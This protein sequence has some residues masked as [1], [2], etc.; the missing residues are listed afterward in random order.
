LQN[1]VTTTER[2]GVPHLVVRG[3]PGLRPPE[4]VPLTRSVV[5]LEPCPETFAL[6]Y[7]LRSPE[8]D[9]I[10][11][12]FMQFMIQE[13]LRR[14]QRLWQSASGRPFFLRTPVHT[15]RDV[16]RYRGFAVRATMTP[17]GGMGLSV[18]VV[19]R[20]ISTR[21]MPDRISRDELGPWKGRTCIYRYGRQWFEVQIEALSD[22]GL[23]EYEI[24][25][26]REAIPLLD[27]IIRES[28]KPIPPQLAQLPHDASVVLYRNNRGEERA[29][30][31]PLCYPTHDTHGAEGGRHHGHTILAPGV[32]RALVRDFVSHNL[33]GLRFGTVHL[34]ISREPVPLP[35]QIFVFPDLAFGQ[36]RVLSVR[37]APEARQI[38]LDALGRER[39]AAM[40][41]RTAGFY[42]RDPL[43][44]QYLLLPK[45]VCDSFGERFVADLRREVDAL[46]AK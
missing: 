34:S 41:D 23:S 22:L 14:D 39:V 17:S 7:N 15:E 4:S 5:R 36:S 30:P 16:G 35:R 40:R 46:Y 25:D 8:N 32:R 20:F 33:Q 18:D 31:A 27:F 2:D 19:H 37:G 10:C 3:D 13:P 21:P 28:Q 26:E 42:T 38:A 29:A 1:P 44:R 6:D 12:R 9:R 45:S 43:D 24:L 11:L